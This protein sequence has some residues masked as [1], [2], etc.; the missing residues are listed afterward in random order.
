MTKRTIYP[1]ESNTDRIVVT[2]AFIT[3]YK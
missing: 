3:V 2:L 1:P